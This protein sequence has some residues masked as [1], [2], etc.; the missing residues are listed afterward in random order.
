MHAHTPEIAVMTPITCTIIYTQWKTLYYW[1]L[2]FWCK[3]KIIHVWDE[4]R[5]S[6]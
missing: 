1:D 6:T 2:V 4:L 5:V 3:D